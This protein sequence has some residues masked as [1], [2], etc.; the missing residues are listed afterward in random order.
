MKT[1]LREL[2]LNSDDFLDREVIVNINNLVPQYMTIGELAEK[3]YEENN[4]NIVSFTPHGIIKQE[5]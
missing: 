4:Q 3:L 1:Y 5:V 2:I